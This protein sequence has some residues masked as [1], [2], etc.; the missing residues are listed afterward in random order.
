ML[1]F[2]KNYF[3]H[4]SPL[5][6]YLHYS[7]MILI[8]LEFITS[9]FIIIS[10]SGEISHK[11]LFYYG[12]LLHIR[13]GMIILFLAIVFTIVEFS[14]HKFSYFFPFSDFTQLKADIEKLKSGEIPN[15]AP[16]GLSAT[17][18]G[19][20]FISLLLTAL[21]G[22]IWFVLW[23]NNSPLANEAKNIHKLLTGF[24]ETYVIIHAV[25]GIAHMLS[26]FDK[27]KK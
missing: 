21:S 13:I 8:L 16:K 25:L 11:A 14:K 19:F 18:E 5:I 23:S 27:S 9:A 20:G 4:F 3:S 6:R 26:I 7:I 12:T 1:K 15:P 24:I 10:P 17:I 22:G 2:I